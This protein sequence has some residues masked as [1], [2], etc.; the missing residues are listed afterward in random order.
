[1]TKGRR[2]RFKRVHGV[3]IPFNLASEAQ[4]RSKL[5]LKPAGQL[6]AWKEVA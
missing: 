1:M 6:D 2:S 3:F 5:K 4:G